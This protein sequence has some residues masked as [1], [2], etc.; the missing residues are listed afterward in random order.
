[1]ARIIPKQG[2]SAANAVVIVDA[3]DHMDGIAAEYAYLE[4]RFGRRGTDWELVIQSLIE[5]PPDEQHPTVRHLDKL[6]IRLSDGSNRA[7]YF[8]IESFF[9]ME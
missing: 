1:M 6:L 2:D 5:E 9:L 8:D 7:I 3:A 4:E